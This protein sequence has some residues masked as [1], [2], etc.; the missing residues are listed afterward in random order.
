MAGIVGTGQNVTMRVVPD[1]VGEKFTNAYI[2][3]EHQPL[4]CSEYSTSNAITFD[5]IRISFVGGRHVV[6]KWTAH[7]HRP[8]C[9]STTTIVNPDTIKITWNS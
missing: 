7:Q 1:S 4:S 5:N 8:A 6:P 3:M 2:V 9:N